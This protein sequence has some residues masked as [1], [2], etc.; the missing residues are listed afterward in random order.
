MQKNRQIKPLVSL[1]SALCLVLVVVLVS[2]CG[3]NTSNTSPTAVP[4][5]FTHVWQNVISTTCQQCHQAGGSAVRTCPSIKVDFSSQTTAYNTLVGT[6]GVPAMVACADV[7]PQCNGVQL[8]APGN[9]S[10]SYMEY[11]VDPSFTGQPKPGCTSYAHQPGVAGISAANLDSLK[12]WIDT[13]KAAN[14]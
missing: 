2:R 7:L 1:G 8:V 12:V 11:L 10:A 9:S 6:G 14:N 13:N 4:G 3:N 5:T